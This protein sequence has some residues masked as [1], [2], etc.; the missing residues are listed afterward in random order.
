MKDCFFGIALLLAGAVTIM[1]SAKLAPV[2]DDSAR[3]KEHRAGATGELVAGEEELRKIVVQWDFLKG[4]LEY[5]ICHDCTISEDGS[6]T[7]GSRTIVPIGRKGECGGRPCHIVRGA[8]LRLNTFHVRANIAD[9]GWTD[10]SAP[11]NFM[12]QDPGRTYHEEL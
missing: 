9:E 6:V 4:A 10:W 12:V 8:P 1:V 3:I 11:R 5:E 7:G 2:L